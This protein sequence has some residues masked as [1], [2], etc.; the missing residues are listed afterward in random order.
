MS[1][2]VPLRR[3]EIRL[4]EDPRRRR[5]DPV[6]E[7][8]ARAAQAERLSVDLERQLVVFCAQGYSSSFAAASLREIGCCNAT[9]MVG[10]FEGWKASGLPVRDL[11][12]RGAEPDALPGM[13]RTSR[14]G[15]VEPASR[16]RMDEKPDYRAW[17]NSR[18]PARSSSQDG[19]FVSRPAVSRSASGDRQDR[20]LVP[21]EDRTA[22]RRLE[23]SH[24]PPPEPPALPWHP[25]YPR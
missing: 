14:S 10:G 15:P 8:R 6:R 21:A 25:D 23:R 24:S 11:D 22:D 3:L 9:D 20:R 19:V 16:T 2:G 13:G 18:R 17:G 7:V 1:E 4:E 5:V 12:E